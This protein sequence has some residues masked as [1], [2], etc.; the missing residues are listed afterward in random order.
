AAYPR[1]FPGAP[2]FSLGDRGVAL[3]PLGVDD[4]VV[5]PG[6]GAVVE[7]HR[8]QHLAA[9]GRQPERDVGDAENGPALGEALLDGAQPLDGLHR[10]AYVVRVAGAHREY[11][12]VEDQ[13]ASREPVLPAE[14]TER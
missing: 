13:V 7:E 14:E 11:Q 9:R 1:P 2:R 4:G 8:V 12:R 5:E 10:R 3:E 6:L